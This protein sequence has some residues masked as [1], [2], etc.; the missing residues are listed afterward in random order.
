MKGTA[1]SHRAQ[2]SG[3]FNAGSNPWLIFAR[4]LH[5]GGH[6]TEEKGRKPPAHGGTGPTPGR[7]AAR[8]SR[9]RGPEKEEKELKRIFALKMKKRLKLD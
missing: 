1:K 5:P 2:P 6:Q 7:T 4:A 9:V 3:A 8:T